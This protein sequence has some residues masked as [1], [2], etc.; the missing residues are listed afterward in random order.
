MSKPHLI[1]LHNGCRSSDPKYKDLQGLCQSRNRPQP[2]D[3]S[4]DLWDYKRV[5]EHTPM[6]NTATR[7]FCK[8]FILST[9]S[10]GEFG[11]DQE[12]Y[13]SEDFAMKKGLQIY[14]CNENVKGFVIVQVK[15]D[16][17]KLIYQSVDSDVDYTVCEQDGRIFI[18]EGFHPTL[19]V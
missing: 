2:L 10:F 1:R 14:N 9:N 17:Q 12:V 5:K 16:S 11:V 6:T 3:L 8:L 4:P 18:K 7:K 15:D 13:L 19:M